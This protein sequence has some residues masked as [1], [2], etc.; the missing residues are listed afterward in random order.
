MT[1]FSF[2]VEGPES[3]HLREFPVPRPG[4]GDLLLEVERV[5]ICGSDPHHFGGQRLNPTF[6]LILGHEVVGTVAAVGPG[7]ADGWVEGD[8]VVVEPYIPCRSC[9][10]C[11]NSNYQLCENK[12]CYGVNLSSA[13]SPHLW[14]AYGQYLFVAAGSRLHRVD[15]QVLGD[16]ACLTSVI[17]NGF[18]WVK[19]KGQV[20]WGETVAIIGAGAQGLAT[21]VAAAVSGAGPIVVLGLEKDRRGFEVARELGADHTI[22]VDRDDAVDRLAEMTAGRM[23]DV[24]VECSGAVGGIAMATDLLRPLGRCVV[25]G[26]PGAQEVSLYSEKLVRKELTVKG[27]LGQAWNVE[28]A[29]RLINSRRLPI[30]KI[31]THRFPVTESVAAMDF[32]INRPDDCIRVSMGPQ[33]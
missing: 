6:P 2:V 9:W 23:A 3:M 32:F 24:V 20:Q 15:A 22:A 28:D 8:R 10:Y 18:R 14:G 12:R 21:V 19:T 17:G 1:T 16:A 5:S 7:V 33:G 25:A 4:E 26:F 30:E 11:Q 29:M 13:E 27:G 31:I